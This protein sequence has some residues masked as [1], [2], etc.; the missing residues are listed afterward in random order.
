MTPSYFWSPAT[1]RGTPAG[2]HDRHL[3]VLG[4]QGAD[5][6]GGMALVLVGQEHLRS[7]PDHDRAHGAV[8]VLDGVSVHLDG[9]LVDVDAALV[10]G[11][12]VAEDVL[13]GTQPNDL[14]AEELA[15][16]EER[17]TPLGVLVAPRHHPR[18][19]GLTE[20]HLLRQHHRL[21][22]DFLGEGEGSPHVVE[23]DPR[24]L[25]RLGGGQRVAGVLPAV[26]QHDDAVRLS[27][28]Q[29]GLGELD[30]LEEIRS[31]PA[32][33]ALRSVDG[34]AVRQRLIDRPL[35]RRRRSR[36]PDRRSARAWPPRPRI[37][38]RARAPPDSRCR[39]RRGGIPR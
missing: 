15:V 31:L 30:G 28:R 9:R 11:L 8:V 10:E 23:V 29:G 22:H 25:G 35:P 1:S 13:A 20:L 21:G 16:P 32:H 6:R 5:Q 17:D 18:L 24:V 37:D 36:S 12:P 39:T 33:R 2:L 4:A 26:G 14:G 34:L 3:D 19:E 7:A 38:R 27:R